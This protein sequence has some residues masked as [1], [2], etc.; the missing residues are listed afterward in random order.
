MLL[1]F[2]LPA[3]SSDGPDTA[4]LSKPL[5]ARYPIDGIVDLASFSATT[6]RTIDILDPALRIQAR[7]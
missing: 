5:P 6:Q 7:R 3:R 4:M 1:R 2:P